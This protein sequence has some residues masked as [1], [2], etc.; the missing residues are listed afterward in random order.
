MP[1]VEEGG[2]MITCV[3]YNRR[4]FFQMYPVYYDVITDPIDLRMI[5]RRI[6]SGGYPSLDELEKDFSLMARNA[7]TFNEPKSLIYQVGVVYG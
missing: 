6:M 4:L 5:A 3:L 7:K 2:E 1:A